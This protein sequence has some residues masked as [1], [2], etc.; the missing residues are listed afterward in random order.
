MT[1][2]IGIEVIDLRDATFDQWLD[3]IL[4]NYKIE[5]FAFNFNIYDH[6]N[7]LFSVELIGSP[8]FD[9]NDD[10][11]AS[12]E[13][14]ASRDHYTMFEYY[15]PERDLAL[16]RITR[17]IMQYIAKGDYARV[18]KRAHAIALGFI[19]GDLRVLLH[20]ED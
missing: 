19:D 15:C 6:K 16:D 5:T 4:E 13:V 18:L 11:W 14:Y 9:I 1:N 3:C 20:D 10:D 8:V 2:D 17:M 12:E 7:C